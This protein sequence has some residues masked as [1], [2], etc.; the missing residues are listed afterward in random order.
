MS[1][2]QL[3]LAAAHR[4][5]LS[6]HALLD[7]ACARINELNVFPVPDADTGTNLF[8]T[9]DGALQYVRSHDS[10]MSEPLTLAQGLELLSRG[11]LLSAR[12]NSGVILS[13]LAAGMSEEVARSQEA[14]GGVVTELDAPMLAAAFERAADL[15]WAGVARPVEGTILSVARAAAQGSRAAADEGQDLH[16]IAEA[17]LRAGSDALSHT[18]EQLPNLA[19]AGVVDAGG[20][21]LLLVIEALEGVLTGRSAQDARRVPT[22]WTEEIAHRPPEANVAI[23]VDGDSHCD[24]SDGTFEVMYL[25]EGSDPESAQRLLQ[26]LV[27]VGASV[28]VV[29]GP[30]QWR[31][32]VHLDDP[33]QALEAGALAGR[34]THVTTSALTPSGGAEPHEAIKTAAR[35]GVGVVACAAGAGLAS[36]F[37]RAGAETVKSHVGARASTGQLLSAIRAVWATDVLVLPNDPDTIL[38]AQAAARAAR[39]EGLSVHVLPTRAAVQGLAALAVWDPQAPVESALEGMAE[40]AGEVTYGSVVQAGESGQTPAGRVQRGQWLGFVSG[41]VVAVSK[42]QGQALKKVFSAAEV[43]HAGP[44]EILTVIAG[45]PAEFDVAEPRVTKWGKGHPEVSIEWL[46]GGQPTFAWLVGME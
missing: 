9:F 32:H 17:A 8:L 13:Q 18:P 39:N 14:S 2:T 42:D 22:W 21:G 40:A 23:A 12:G 4:W 34:I 33:R 25:L 10:L 30:T 38:V 15:A 26:H 20:A 19:R 31:V 44:V 28:L 7:E 29:G 16:E 6:A 11:M 41:E 37:S 45:Q 36:A 5:A 24:H 3:D 1:Q 43:A 27:R 35:P 46:T